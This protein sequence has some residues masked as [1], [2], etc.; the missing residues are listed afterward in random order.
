MSEDTFLQ[1]VINIDVLSIDEQFKKVPAELAYYNQKYA[2]ALEE[3]LI[4][5]HDME[6]AHANAYEW[7]SREHDSKGKK[8]TVA[9]IEARIQLDEDYHNAKLNFIMKEAEKARLRG[10]VD[11]VSAKKEML[12]SLGAH[13]RVEMSDPLVKAQVAGKRALLEPDY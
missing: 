12:I 2:D 9:A 7:L 10:K 6:R 13:L 11:V 1:D 5:K 8:L 4:A 3:H